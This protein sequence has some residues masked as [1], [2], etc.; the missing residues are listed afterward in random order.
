MSGDHFVM[1]LMTLNAGAALFYAL[2]G[3][4]IKVLYWCSVVVLNFCILKMH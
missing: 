1:A 2:D 4:W 3:H